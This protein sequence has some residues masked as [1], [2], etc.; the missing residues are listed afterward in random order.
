LAVTS[1]DP[2]E[3][4]ALGVATVGSCGPRIGSRAAGH[5]SAGVGV[6]RVDDRLV[7]TSSPRLVH[8]GTKDREVSL[9]CQ[10]CTQRAAGVPGGCAHRVWRP[11]YGRAPHPRGHRDRGRTARAPARSRSRMRRPAPRFISRLR[12]SSNVF[13]SLAKEGVTSVGITRQDGHVVDTA[14]QHYRIL[15]TDLRGG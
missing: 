3:L 8:P 11:G 4:L 7:S 1:A 10:L 6:H 9:R 12:I 2:F 15:T 13:M 14:Q 5:D